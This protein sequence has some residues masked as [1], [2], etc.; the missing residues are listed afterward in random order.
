MICEYYLFVVGPEYIYINTTG[1]IVEQLASWTYPISTFYSLRGIKHFAD[2]LLTNLKK[3]PEN[4]NNTIQRISK[5]YFRA[6][7]I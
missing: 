2:T 6:S 4:S 5:Y 3:S 7:A 1:N